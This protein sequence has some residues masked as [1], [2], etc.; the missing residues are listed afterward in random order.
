MESNRTPPFG[1]PPSRQRRVL[2][3]FECWFDKIKHFLH[4]LF[5]FFGDGSLQAVSWGGIGNMGQNGKQNSRMVNKDGLLFNECNFSEIVDSCFTI[6]AFLARFHN[7]SSKL[8]F[9]K[10][11]HSLPESI[12][13][14][15]L[16]A[17]NNAPRRRLSQPFRSRTGGGSEPGQAQIGTVPK[18]GDQ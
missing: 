9:S 2:H 8:F 4:P 5:F 1:S 3:H 17:N 10:L 16:R 18:S 7:N 11:L 15:E 14:P 6:V 13:N 12:L